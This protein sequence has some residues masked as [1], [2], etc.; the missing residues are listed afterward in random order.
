MHVLLET[1]RLILRRFTAADLDHLF[2]LDNDPEVMRYINGG[3]PTPREAI[4]S[5]ILPRFMQ[6]D[7]GCPAYGF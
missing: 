7:E 3:E 4:E 1:E 5:D 2:T 6:Y